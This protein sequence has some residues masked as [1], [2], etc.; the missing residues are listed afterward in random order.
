MVHL[1]KIMGVLVLGVLCLAPMGLQAER[2]YQSIL[3]DWTQDDEAYSWE[4]LEAR[5]V[6][7]ATYLSPD[8]MDAQWKYLEQKLKGQELYQE[9][10]RLNGNTPTGTSDVFVSAIYVGSRSDAFVGKNPSLWN[11]VLETSEGEVYKASAMEELP[12]N[13]LTKLLFPYID[14]WSRIYKLTFP[15]VIRASTEW[16]QLKMVGI[17]ADSTLEWNLRRLGQ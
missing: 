7:H 5:L 1:S 10:L 14:R 15:K 8:V 2:S 16:V 9:Q 4:N 13:E 12:R 6:W 17:P 11:I 3:K